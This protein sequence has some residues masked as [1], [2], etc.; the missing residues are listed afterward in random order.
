MAKHSALCYTC[1]SCRTPH[2]VTSVTTERGKKL[3]VRCASH[4]FYKQSI[5]D[6][7]LFTSHLSLFTFFYYLCPVLFF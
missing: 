2:L 7:I 5:A 1:H 3:K 4:G 6:S